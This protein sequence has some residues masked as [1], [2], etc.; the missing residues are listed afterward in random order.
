MKKS[1]MALAAVALGAL[2]AP[3][4]AQAAEKTI[5]FMR[6]G[7]DPYYQYGM[8]AA[9]AAADKLG[10]KLVTYT[11]NN[12]PTQEL[13]NVQDAITKGVDGILIYAVSLSSEKAAIA[14]AQRAGVP[15]FFQYGY[16]PSL[17]KNAAGFMEINLFKFGEP[18]GEALGK[19]VPDGEVAIVTG[20]LGRGDAEAFAN[21]FK[22]GLKAVGSKASVVAEVA[23]DWDRQKA[24][25][26]T[27]QILTAHPDVKAIYAA[28]DDMAVGV[29]IAIDRAG[30][31]G[32]ILLGACNGAPYGIDLIKQ[33][34]MTITNSNPPS[35]AS[36][37]SLQL[38]LAVIDKKIEPG[39]FYAAPTQLITSANMDTAIPW[40]AK[41]DQVAAWLAQPLP[42]P[43]PGP[44]N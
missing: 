19:Q 14:Q 31:T 18:V 6:G 20:K 44:T 8:N 26:A 41:P 12:D 7:P 30:K 17:L 39:Q 1:T 2:I 38:L 25:D 29:S 43:S 24:L 9:Q 11:A 40:D 37:Q 33:G 27:A 28:N 22:D 16:D 5:A 36:V 35:I 15:I 21:S 13:A 4:F 32:K 10:V 34:K 42:Q 3:T 23:A